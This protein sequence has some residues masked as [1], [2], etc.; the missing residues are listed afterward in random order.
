MTVDL[1][2]IKISLTPFKWK[3]TLFCTIIPFMKSY[4]FG[5]IELSYFVNPTEDE[6]DK[7]LMK[8]S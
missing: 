6:I 3:R 1:K 7:L 2:T 4:K 5:P 8:M